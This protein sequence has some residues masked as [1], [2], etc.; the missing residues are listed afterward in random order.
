MSPF[1]LCL[2][3]FRFQGCNPPGKIGLFPQSHTTLEA[4]LGESVAPLP[5]L[6]TTPPNSIDSLDEEIPAGRRHRF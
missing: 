4:R 5:H 6:V 2:P 1:I 3:L